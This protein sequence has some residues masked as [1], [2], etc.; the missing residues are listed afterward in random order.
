M[1]RSFAAN[2]IADK[3]R[4]LDYDLP[5]DFLDTHNAAI[6]DFEEAVNQQNEGVATRKGARASLEDALTRAEEEL[7][8]CDTA[9]RNRVK[10]AGT[11]SAW[12]S[13]RR[14]ERA[15]QKQKAKPMTATATTEK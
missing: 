8:R 3:S 14:L 1:A 11:L 15:P 4:F 2:A 6:E 5:A 12:E 7:E 9:L 10:D 13:A